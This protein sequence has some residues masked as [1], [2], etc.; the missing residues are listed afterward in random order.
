MH[1]KAGLAAV[2]S[3]FIAFVVPVT[4]GVNPDA[5]LSMA[6]GDVVQAVETTSVLTDAVVAAVVSVSDAC[7]PGSTPEEIL[8]GSRTI[9]LLVP[10]SQSAIRLIDASG[11]PLDASNVPLDRFEARGMPKLL[12]GDPIVQEVYGR[13]LRTLV[14]LTSDMHGN[15]ATCHTGF[16][17][18]PSGTVVGAA[19]FDV[20]L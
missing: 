3:L 5:Q 1:A 10:E 15:C 18:M 19:G 14:P 11:D 20:R 16:S 13:R 12:A 8:A 7:P 9:S 2:T 4:S 17:A 6:A